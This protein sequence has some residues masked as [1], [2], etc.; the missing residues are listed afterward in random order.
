MRQLF[1]VLLAIACIP[2]L[3]KRKIPVG[4]TLLLAGI[5][6]GG[7]AGILPAAILEA[8]TDVFTSQASLSSVLIVIEIGMLSYLMNCYGILMKAERAL[9][10]LVPNPRAIIMLLP[11]MVGA[12]QAPGGAAL[13]APFVN[14]LGKE[15]GLSKAQRSNINMIARHVLMLLLPF[16]TNM[17]IVHDLVPDLSIPKLA[18]LNLGFVVLM[19]GAGYF[20][21]LRHSQ[22]IDM[23]KAA[24]AERLD[25]LG[26]LLF[27]LSP[28]YL[29]IILKAAFNIPYTLALIF[30]MLV[31]FFM[32]DKED[33]LKR[34]KC[35]FNRNT[36]LMIVGIYFFQNI[37]GRMAEMLELFSRLIGGQTGW[38]FLALVALVGT[39]F[40]LSTGLMYLAVGILIPIAASLP[41][42]SESARL[43][44]LS[45]TFCWSFL[46]YFFSP[47][48]LCQLLTD[49]EVGCTVGE[50][51]HN[52]LPFMV[53]LPAI[54][55]LLYFLYHLILP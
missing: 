13:S 37:V 34:L 51:Y 55:V 14:N 46:G 21:L 29:V 1:A 28:I 12:L 5:L 47:I 25:A 36:A 22:P 17:L 44:A 27:A 26:R 39:V 42:T 11:T 18:V 10:I 24:A 49:Q 9:R 20:F 30:S 7:T 31:V 48:H 38:A 23:P 52:Y 32:S 40:G 50:R 4:P 33:F 8:F 35:S 54:T 2:I 41:Y 15:M 16:S 6:A 19:Q 3:L 45:Y 53:V 43:I